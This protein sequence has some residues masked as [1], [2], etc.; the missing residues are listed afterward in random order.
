MPCPLSVTTC[1]LPVALS[2]IESVPLTVPLACGVKVTETVQL[3]PTAREALQVVVWA[4]PL[5]GRIAVSETEVV[6][7]F[8]IVTTFA[9]LVVPFNCVP[10]VRL[11]GDKEI[12]V[13]A[14]AGRAKARSR[15]D[16]TQAQTKLRE[17]DAQGAEE[18]LRSSRECP[19]TDL[20]SVRN[21]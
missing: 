5:L 4:N 12:V 8:V 1:G 16:A 21:D 9:A 13:D 18:K 6:P 19:N 3:A 11:V 15:T 7:V 10:N 17:I 2:V 20:P 14:C